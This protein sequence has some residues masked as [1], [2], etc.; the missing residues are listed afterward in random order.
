MSAG[1]RGEAMNRRLIAQKY[2]EVA[3]LAAS[4]EGGAVN[5]VVVG[6]AVLAGIA[7]GDAI[8]LTA[9]GERYAGT[10]HSEAVSVL[11]RV[12]RELADHLAKLVRLKPPSH[13]GNQFVS[14][15]DRTAALRAAR[16][17]VEAATER[18]SRAG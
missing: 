7:A 9:L 8:C 17:L 1:G 5:N 15:T 11:R 18:T 2:L 13:Y 4:E 10:D 6:V 16:K 14:T 3:E 12:A